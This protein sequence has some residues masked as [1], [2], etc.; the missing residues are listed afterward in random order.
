MIDIN[1][2]AY[3]GSQLTPLCYIRAAARRISFTLQ[4][5][6]LYEPTTHII[7]VSFSIELGYNTVIP[8][9]IK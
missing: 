4:H 2:Y 9:H 1:N 5:K 7:Q 6:L 3:L 8:S